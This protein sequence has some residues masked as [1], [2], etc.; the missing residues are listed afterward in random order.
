MLLVDD[1]WEEGLWFLGL[2]LIL[3]LLGEVQQLD[4]WSQ[5]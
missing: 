5:Y 3:A 4:A 1:L 2:Y